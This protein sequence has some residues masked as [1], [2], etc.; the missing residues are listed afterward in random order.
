MS[1]D[2]N[3]LQNAEAAKLTAAQYAKAIEDASGR[4]KD[5]IKAFTD[6]DRMRV[7]DNALRELSS[8]LAVHY[9]KPN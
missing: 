3:A 1:S 5:A 6:D 9:G 4:V 7:L 8:S 2:P